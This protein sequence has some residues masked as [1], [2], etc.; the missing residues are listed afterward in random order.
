MALLGSCPCMVE[1]LHGFARFLH[2]VELLHGFAKFL[3]M[4]GW[5]TAWLCKVLAH[6]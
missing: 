2:M 4:H 6:G 3:H 5:A 1:L